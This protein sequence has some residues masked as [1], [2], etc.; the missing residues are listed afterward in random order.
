MDVATILGGALYAVTKTGE[1]LLRPG[2]T[3]VTRGVKH[4]WSNR[5][6]RPVRVVATMVS[7]DSLMPLLRAG[8]VLDGDHGS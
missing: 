5:T 2:D 1:T 4:I 6:D 7:G 8:V 3:F